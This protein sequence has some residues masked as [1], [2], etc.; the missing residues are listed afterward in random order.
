MF[1][2][3]SSF[4]LVVV[5]ALSSFACASQPDA[6]AEDGVSD[7]S[8]LTGAQKKCSRAKY[9]EALGYYKK[10]VAGAKG[11]ATAD[12]C[13]GTI[14][15]GY[16]TEIAANALKAAH[17]CEAFEGV[18]KTSPYAASLRETLRD[19]LAYRVA[20]GDLD[21]T[22]R[23]LSAALPGVRMDGGLGHSDVWTLQFA[24]G[25]HG[26]VHTHETNGVEDAYLDKPIRWAVDQRDGKTFVEITGISASDVPIQTRYL[27]VTE[28]EAV[29]PNDEALTS[30]GLERE[31]DAADP[32]FPM[33]GM[34]WDSEYECE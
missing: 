23:N 7:D 11:R 19:T 10:A 16:K 5:M 21:P 30:I 22:W 17:I 34:F 6:D 25:G 28:H 26:T 13:D 32:A 27:L 12:V 8:A 2:R 31:S 29:G 20:T 18:I 14:E 3:T 9:D 1:A 15:G 33:A 24:A 4:A